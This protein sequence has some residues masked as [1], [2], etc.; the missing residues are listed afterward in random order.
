MLGTPTLLHVSHNLLI[1]T[2]TV[3]TKHVLGSLL[4]AME[5]FVGKG[6]RKAVLLLAEDAEV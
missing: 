3:Q 1:I 4:D 6:D 2:Q 5:G